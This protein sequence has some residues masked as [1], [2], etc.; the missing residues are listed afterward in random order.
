MI[1][2]NTPAKIFAANEEAAR[3]L[4]RQLVGKA[5]GV[6]RDAPRGNRTEGLAAAHA[7]ALA[8]RKAG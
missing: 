7:D 3:I 1:S 6:D 2:H 4:E 8:R 5:H